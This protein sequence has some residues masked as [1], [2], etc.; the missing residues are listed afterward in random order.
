MGGKIKG[1]GIYANNA[2]QSS[3]TARF[4]NKSLI[5]IDNIISGGNLNSVE[6]GHGILSR[7]RHSRETNEDP[8]FINQGEILIGGHKPITGSGIRLENATSFAGRQQVFLNDT[9]GVLTINQT[10]KHGIHLG[11][12][13]LP[14]IFHNEGTIDIGNQTTIGGNGILVDNGFFKHFPERTMRINAV[15]GHGIEVRGDIKNTR[16]FDAIFENEGEITM[17]D[18]ARIDGHGLLLS[19]APKQNRNAEAEFNNRETGIL[20][21][22]RVGK[23][24]IKMEERLNFND[25]EVKLSNEN[26][27]HIGINTPA[28]DAIPAHGFDVI[29]GIVTFTD[30]ALTKIDNVESHGFRVEEGRVSLNGLLEIGLTRGI[31][32][33]GIHLLGS[34]ADIFDRSTLTINKVNG[35]GVFVSEGDST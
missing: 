21:I 10:G 17:G 3:D 32:E 9:T 33:D 34:L 29:Q 7:Q 13:V 28:N 25:G 5:K 2:A 35:N 27:I 18:A 31:G 26:I 12:Q 20:R 6:T 11:G 24:G 30:D 16:R 22:D 19:L 14:M 23:S 1:V 8:N 4:V 15:L